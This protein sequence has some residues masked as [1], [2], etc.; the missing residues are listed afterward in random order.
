MPRTFVRNR[1]AP[2]A[3]SALLATRIAA[4]S[5]GSRPRDDNDSGTTAEGAFQSDFH[6]TNNFD[7]ATNNFDQQP[8]HKACDAVVSGAGNA[9]AS[10]RNLPWRYIRGHTRLV[11]GPGQ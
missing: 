1:A 8:L 7:C 6:I 4:V 3:S 10:A 2:T 9:R 5:N 11:N